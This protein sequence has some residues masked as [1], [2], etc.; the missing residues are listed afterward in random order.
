MLVSV[1]AIHPPFPGRDTAESAMLDGLKAERNLSATKV[2]TA[3]ETVTFG[4]ARLR[5]SEAV[6]GRCRGGDPSTDGTI[7]TPEL[8]ACTRSR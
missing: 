5:P 4:T 3:T 2:G 6:V 1:A 7:R 8:P